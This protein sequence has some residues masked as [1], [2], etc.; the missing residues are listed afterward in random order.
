MLFLQLPALNGCDPASLGRCK[1]GSKA[2]IVLQEV[3]SDAQHWLATKVKYRQEIEK[4]TYK[5]AANRQR[6]KTRHTMRQ[7]RGSS[8]VSSL[9]LVLAPFLMLAVQMVLGEDNRL[10]NFTSHSQ[11]KLKDGPSCRYRMFFV[12][13]DFV[14]VGGCLKQLLSSCH[15]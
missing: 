8:C 9:T 12:V 3:S 10:G 15:P 1:G 6:N 4:H 2:G 14:L 13:L 11:C 5:A 7:N